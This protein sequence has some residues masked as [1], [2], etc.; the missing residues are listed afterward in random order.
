MLGLVSIIMPAFN[1]DQYISAAIDSVVQQT[2]RSWELI[3]VDD[4]ST[5]STA[6]IAQKAVAQDPRIQF[7]KN[8]FKTG[9]YGARNYAIGKS[10]GQWTAFFD[11]DDLWRYDKLEKSLAFQVLLNAPMVYT[12]YRRINSSGKE[13]SGDIAIPAFL[14]YN[15]LLG[16]TAIVTSSV[17]IDRTRVG[18]LQMK[19]TYYDDF[20]CWL[21]ILKDYGKA[22][23]VGDTLTLYRVTPGSLSRNK[24]RSARKVW[25]EL[26]QNQTLSI[27]D[28]SRHFLRYLFN[29][30][31]KYR[32]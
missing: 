5:D 1:C 10:K 2:Y 21:R 17:I 22:F 31:N 23:G 7:Y 29:A 26:R 16:N 25:L 14:T 18:N 24:I 12:S 27:V 20:D 9:A 4:H 8:P 28:S 13:I 11:G 32:K 6:A 15:E 19:N 3:I 30:L